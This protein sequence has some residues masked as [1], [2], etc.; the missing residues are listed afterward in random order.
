MGISSDQAIDAPTAT[1]VRLEGAIWDAGASWTACVEAVAARYARVRALDAAA[2][3]AARADAPVAER[4]AAQVTALDTWAAG[5][6]ID[7]EREAVRFFDENA[8][9]FLRPD[10]AI[11]QDLRRRAASG[12]SIT[13]ESV[14]P[15]AVAEAI[16][17]HL[18]VARAATGVA[19]RS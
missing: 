3:L 19:G 10:R 9:R 17:R 4:L 8:P 7:W 13:L 15:A 1:R 14:L 5:S 16:A 2:V 12:E 11:T 18:G 6:D